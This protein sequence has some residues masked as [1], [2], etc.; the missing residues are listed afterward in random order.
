MVLDWNDLEEMKWNKMIM[1]WNVIPTVLGENQQ[2]TKI[3]ST[4]LHKH[5]PNHYDRMWYHVQ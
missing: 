4:H 3:N 2:W 1:T 5:S